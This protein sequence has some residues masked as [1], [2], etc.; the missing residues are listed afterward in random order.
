MLTAVRRPRSARFSSAAPKLQGGAAPRRA[1]LCLCASVECGA[2][3]RVRFACA[4]RARP[5]DCGECA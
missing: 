3:C 2:R 4:H 1:A 5:A